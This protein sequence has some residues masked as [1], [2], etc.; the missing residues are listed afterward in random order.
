MLYQPWFLPNSDLKKKNKLQTCLVI[1]ELNQFLCISGNFRFPGLPWHERYN[2]NDP[3]SFFTAHTL[4]QSNA[5]TG[6]TV[7][8]NT[9]YTCTIAFG[10]HNWG[11]TGIFAGYPAQVQNEEQVINL[12]ILFFWPLL[13]TYCYLYIANWLILFKERGR[14]V[15]VFCTKKV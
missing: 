12:L 2:G 8:Y 10:W 11:L 3:K 5:S 6:M 14:H 7:Y 15:L 1:W 9:T 13:V 4:L